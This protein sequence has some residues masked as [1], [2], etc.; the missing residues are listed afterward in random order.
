[1][2]MSSDQNTAQSHCI[3]TGDSSIE[4]AGTD[5]IFWNNSNQNSVQEEIKR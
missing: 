1:M 5:E 4:R 3:Q 2:A